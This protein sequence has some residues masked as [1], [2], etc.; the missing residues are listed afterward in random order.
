[1]DSEHAPEREGGTRA[2]SMVGPVL[3][4]IREQALRLSL[5]ARDYFGSHWPPDPRLTPLDDR[6]VMNRE[7]L[8]ISARLSQVVL[9]ALSQD[10]GTDDEVA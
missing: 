2:T 1:M 5:E 6:M 9:W 4:N 7:M 3:R 10:D 8:F